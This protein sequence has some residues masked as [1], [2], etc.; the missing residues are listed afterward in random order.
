MYTYA[1][2]PVVLTLIA[3]LFPFKSKYDNSNL[4]KVSLLIA[5]YNEE[6]I[7]KKKI[8]NVLSLKYP[9]E[10]IEVIIGSDASSDRTDE[11]ISQFGEQINFIRFNSRSGKSVVLNKLVKMASGDVLVFS[12]ANT[13]FNSDAINKMVPY[14]SDKRVGGVCG[15]LNIEGETDSSLGR[16]EKHY[17]D[18]ESKI[19]ENEGRLGRVM[20]SNGAI[21]AIKKELYSDIPT[22][23]LLMDDFFIT[24]NVLKQH[25]KV[26]YEKNAGAT[27]G[28]SAF[29]IGEFTR[30]KRISTANFNYLWSQIDILFSSDVLFTLIF[31]SHKLV[32]WLSPFLL[33]GALVLNSLLVEDE[34]YIYLL[35]FQIVFYFLSL[36]GLFSKSKVR[37]LSAPYYFVSVNVALFLGFFLSLVP[38]QSA[39]WK[40]VDR[41]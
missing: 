36:I 12:D 24:L 16:W 2:F 25:K 10:K 35:L 27:E 20:G 30:K 26:V 22:N 7:I 34:K 32:R 11:I 5:A 33:I 4:P 23:R 38:K 8:E 18:M 15:K 17:W 28:T 19:K 37:V 41:K 3:R 31:L 14:F 13:L 29:D 21:Y 6:A 9:Q 40:R 39:T 1:L